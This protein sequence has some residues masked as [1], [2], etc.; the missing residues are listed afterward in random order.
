M[1]LNGFCRRDIRVE[2][3]KD[4]GK[5]IK[6]A[7]PIKKIMKEVKPDVRDKN[8]RDISIIVIHFKD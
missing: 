6:K 8:V 2:T 1:K 7:D 5:N 4:T 3:I